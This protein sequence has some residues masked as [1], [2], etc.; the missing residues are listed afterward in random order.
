MRIGIGLPNSIPGC[1]GPLLKEW[2]RSAEAAGFSTVAAIDRIA[3]A[4]HDPMTSLAV[5]ASVTNRIELVANIVVG[6][7]RNAVLLAK[8]AATIQAVSEG[9]LVLGLGA[10]DRADDFLLAGASFSGR[11]RALDDLIDT[12]RLAWSGEPVPGSDSPVISGPITIPLLVA[13]H[14]EHGVKRAVRHSNGWTAGGLSPSEVAPLAGRVRQLWSEAGREGTPRIMALA[15]F[16]LGHDALVGAIAYL[17]GYYEWYGIDSDE[18]TIV[19]MLLCDADAV[20]LA[21]EAYRDAGVDDLVVYP[22][23]AHAVQVDRLASALQTQI[24]G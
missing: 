15:Y 6:P 7:T 2:A 20:R 24:H 21:V 17:S 16:A 3:Y 11:G 14:G 5:A 23:V 4:T 22:A 19:D 1:P 18:Q 9:R 8:E 12:L 13:G 10:G